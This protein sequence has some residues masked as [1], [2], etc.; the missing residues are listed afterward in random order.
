MTQIKK[1]ETPNKQNWMDELKNVIEAKINSFIYAME[2]NND[3]MET[4]LKKGMEYLKKY[5][6]GLKE[7]RTKLLQERTPNG[8]KLVKETHD[9][10]KNVNNDFIESNVGLKTHH[11][12]KINM[13][14]FDGK[15]IVRWILQMEQ[16][17]DLHNVQNTQKVSIE[18]LYLE[19][20]QFSWYRSILSCKKN[21]YLVN[22]YG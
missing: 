6:E 4:I 14:K 10:N 22:F 18:T 5:M 7:G 21:G 9:K 11:I 16:Y 13:R 15:D 17:F 1:I 2:A 12:P 8:G 20:N 3:G 19:P